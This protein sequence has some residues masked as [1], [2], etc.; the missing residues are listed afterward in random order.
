MSTY[1]PNF[2]LLFLNLFTYF[3]IANELK[4]G[5][6]YLENYKLYGIIW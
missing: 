5:H 2:S 4:L 3:N 6:L 1:I